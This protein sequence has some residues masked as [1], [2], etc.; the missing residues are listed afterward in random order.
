MKSNTPHVTILDDE[1][2][3][4]RA[5]GRLLREH[6]FEVDLFSDGP[7]FFA[8]QTDAPS[9]CLLL[10]LDMFGMNGF[11]VLEQLESSL[12]KQ[13]PVIVITGCDFPG[14]RERARRLGANVFLT[15]PV[16]EAPLLDAIRGCLATS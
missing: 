13:T 14:H 11:S 6:G 15:K 10:D 3:F 5:L 16:D 9:D 4:G 7:S 12:S 2:A 8:A 1:P